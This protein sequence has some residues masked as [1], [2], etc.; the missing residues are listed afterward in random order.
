MDIIDQILRLTDPEIL[1]DTD[2]NNSWSRCAAYDRLPAIHGLVVT[3]RRRLMLR[4]GDNLEDALR[5]PSEGEDDHCVLCGDG[6]EDWGN[7]PE[8]VSSVGRCCDA[9]NWNEVI[10]ARIGALNKDKI[11]KERLMSH[12]EFSVLTDMGMI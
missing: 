3:L 12:E 4:L 10:P 1:P 11:E 5:F 8:P 2:T 9:C 6:I 7:N